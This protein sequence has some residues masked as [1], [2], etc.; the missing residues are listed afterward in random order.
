MFINKYPVV[1]VN[2]RATECLSTITDVND[3]MLIQPPE[4]KQIHPSI[5]EKTLSDNQIT[6][7]SCRSKQLHLGH[8]HVDLKS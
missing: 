4:C 1:T 5:K 7:T 6:S 3:S 2:S 8:K